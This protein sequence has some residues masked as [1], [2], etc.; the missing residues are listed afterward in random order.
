MGDPD[1]I[2]SYGSALAWQNPFTVYTFID[3][4]AQYYGI[5]S[6]KGY[7]VRTDVLTVRELVCDHPA[8]M[9]TIGAASAVRR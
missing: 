8:W 2:K 3:G 7:S 9:P 6:Y 5:F 1:R 4:P